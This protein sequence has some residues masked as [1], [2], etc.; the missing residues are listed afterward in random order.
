[1]ANLDVRHLEPDDLDHGLVQAGDL[2]G[3]DAPGLPDGLAVAADGTL[4]ATGPGGVLV[5]APDGTRLVRIETGGPIANAAFGDDGR[6]LY[7]T[8]GAMLARVRLRIAGPA[9]AR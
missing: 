5:F 1:M 6:T 3:D 8:S 9:P 7:M 4:F 2:V